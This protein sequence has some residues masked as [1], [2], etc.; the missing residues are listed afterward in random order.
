M[1]YL[2]Y[3]K[4]VLI[5]NL[6]AKIFSVVFQ[7]ILMPIFSMVLIFQFNNT[8]ANAHDTDSELLIY[9]L[10]MSFT[11]IFPLIVF[12]IFY[13]LGL[14]TDVNLT[15]RRERIVPF[16]ISIILFGVFYYLVRTNHFYSNIIY[17]IIFGS[18]AITAIANTITMFW[19]ISIHCL[20]VSSVLGTIVGL[21]QITPNNHF[22]LIL[23][24]SIVV[25]VIGVSRVILKRHTTA[26]VIAGTSLGFLGTLLAVVYN[27]YI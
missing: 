21:S 18:L 6:I 11:I 22:Y 12:G 10:C 23:G 16:F 26:Q 7:P 2:R 20:G 15:K 1:T 24:L 19:K 3:I 13:K 9:A 25:L 4:N 27:I 17:A 8:V 14:V 5:V